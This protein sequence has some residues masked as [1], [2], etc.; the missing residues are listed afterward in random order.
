MDAQNIEARLNAIEAKLD[1][2]LEKKTP[3]VAPV[4]PFGKSYE[5]E[6]GK[7]AKTPE[8]I[9]AF[10]NSPEICAIKAQMCDLGRRIWAKDFVDGNGGNIT[11][12]VGDNLVL[13]TP[14]LVSKGFMKPED[15]CLIDFDGKQLAGTQRRTSEAMTHLEVLKRV[16]NARACVHAHPPHAT[17]FAISN[18]VP[19]KGIIPEAEI[20]LG[21]I[22]IAEYQ[23][24]G[25]PELAD[26]VAACATEHQAVIMKNHGVICWGKNAEDAYW[27]V[28]ILDAYC[29]TLAI[30]LQLGRGLCEIKPEKVRELEKIRAAL[31]K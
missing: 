24:P 4:N 29:H 25:A 14:T 28:E 9:E 12:R 3:K 17:A 19:A 15:I 18:E 2:L 7:D 21:N 27:R 26:T 8:A 13:C 5:W 1:A 11:V 10:F 16:P 30:A 22:G 6:P 23:T 31:I 20:F